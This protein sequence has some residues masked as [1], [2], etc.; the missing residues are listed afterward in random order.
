[1]Y[2]RYIGK[3][4]DPYTIGSMVKRYKNTNYKMQILYMKSMTIDSCDF[5]PFENKKRL[6]L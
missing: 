6:P 5:V 3:S 1:M 2:V 4:K